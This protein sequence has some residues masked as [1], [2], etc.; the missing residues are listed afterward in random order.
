MAKITLFE[1]HLDGSEFTANAP[2]SGASER[3]ETADEATETEDSGAPVGLFAVA[4]V[5]VLVV[6]AVVVRK[7]R[8]DTD[9]ND[10][11]DDIACSGPV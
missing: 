2:W 9:I 1:L 6:L 4:A 7:V 3:G 11:T 8:G 10:I 5:L